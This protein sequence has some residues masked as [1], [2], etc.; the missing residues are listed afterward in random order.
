MIDYIVCLVS[1]FCLTLVFRYLYREYRPIS[2]NGK[3]VFITG[4]SNGIGE[5]LAVEFHKLGAYV[6]LSGRNLEDLQRVVKKLK[7]SEIFQLDLSDSSKVMEMTENFFETH[8][9]DILINNA[10]VSQRGFANE[11]LQSIEIE[12]FLMEVNYFS[13]IALTKAF[14]KSLNG[15]PATVVVTSSTAGILPSPGA[16]G[17]SAAKCGIIGYFTAMRAE[18]KDLGINVVNIVPGFINTNL[19]LRAVNS[20]MKNLGILDP[21]N[22][23]GIQPEDLAKRAVRAIAN[24]DTQIIIAKKLDFRFIFLAS[25]SPRLSTLWI[26]KVALSFVKNLCKVD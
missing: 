7:N 10:G 5:N 12:R 19:T 9:V 17:Y 3:V 18:L 16:S 20:K 6:I 22:K 11:S 13:V 23:N 14:V 25:V 26:K 1:F 24:G 8:K 15:R 2:F 21:R 4:S